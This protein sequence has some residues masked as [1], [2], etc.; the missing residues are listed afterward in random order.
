VAVLTVTDIPPGGEGRI[1]VTFNSR[2]KKG[3]QKKTITV[4]SND[5][6]KPRTI[7]DISA[8]VEVEFGFDQ[9]FLDMGRIRNGQAESRTVA[10]MLKDISKR[11]LLEI[12]SQSPHVTARVVGSPA[13]SEGRL[14]VEVAVGPEMPPGRINETVTAR[15]TDGSYPVAA[16]LVSGNVVGNVEV[17]PETV[18]FV[19]DTSSSGTEQSSQMVRVVSTQEGAS[20]RL[21]G[22][23]DLNDLLAFEIETLVADKQYAITMKPRKNV[24][25]QGRDVSGVVIILTDD[26]IQ[27]EVRVPY[28]I[29]FPRK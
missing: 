18:R 4:E 8:V 25:E 24:A 28:G 21:L 11:Q 14:E 13:G 10:L 17:I 6:R 20:L 5:P 19:L 2:N 15:V 16:L 9:Y 1:E 22:I 12:S 3:P 27:S 7:I 23:R 26:P 29:V